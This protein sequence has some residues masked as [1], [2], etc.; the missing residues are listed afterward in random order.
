MVAHERCNSLKRFVGAACVHRRR[1][2]VHDRQFRE[3]PA[4]RVGRHADVPVGDH[5][6]KSSVTI[7][8]RNR[9]AVMFPHQLSRPIKCIAR[10]AGQGRC[11]HDLAN[12]HDCISCGPGVSPPVDCKVSTGG[13]FPRNGRC[14]PLPRIACT[15]RSHPRHERKE[16]GQ[17]QVLEHH[18]DAFD[19]PLHHKR[20]Q[21]SGLAGRQAE[22]DFDESLH[23]HVSGWQT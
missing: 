20:L 5:A 9:T 7:D 2:H 17:F 22:F 23:C 18:S 3:R 13:S 21:L 11:A 6:K 4:L 12:L 8:D 1:H 16:F 14:L 15:S 19:L 10:L